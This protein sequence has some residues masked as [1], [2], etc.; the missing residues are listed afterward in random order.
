M[1]KYL[2]KSKD[3]LFSKIFLDPNN[4]RTAPEDRQGY[5]DPNTIFPESVQEPLLAR[6][7]G[8][9]EV[10]SLEPTITS[11]GWMP[12]DPMLVWEHPKKAGHYVV[13]EGNTRTVVLRRIRKKLVQE[14]AHLEKMEKN[15]A[16]YDKKDL[17]DQRK[18]VAKL[19]QIVTDTDTLNV[20]LIKAKS[21]AELEEWLPMLHGVRHI[22]H[23]QP[24][25]PYGTNLYLLSRYRQLF[26][27]ENGEKKDLTLD[28][29]IIQKL[30]DSVSLKPTKA[31][32][33]I[34]AAAAFSH[35]KKNYEH[36]MLKD[37][38]FTDQ[39]QYFFEEILQHEYPRKRFGF[40]KTDLHLSAEMEDVLFK[41]AFALPRPKNPKEGENPN[42]FRIAEDIRLWHQM[43][44]YD[45]RTGTTFAD[46]F[47][48]EDPD[49]APGMGEVEAEYLQKRAQV[50]PLV[51]LK[52]LLESL[53]DLKADT[54]MSQASHL[55]PMLKE[56]IKQ[57]ETYLT[58][59]EAVGT[60]K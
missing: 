36:K 14:A 59:I 37:E 41:W 20:H 57:A 43:S 13:I 12:I 38:S 3:V 48:V 10:D 21:A 22:S 58:M 19:Q 33:R 32:Q 9:N 54:L 16:K 31:R 25:S 26:E 2:D 11:R 45:N 50:S 39:D 60:K 56:V 4:P 17:E 1:H 35:F 24:W 27:A 18:L 15:K 55:R 5:E 51:T 44:R 49:S 7:E 34:Q 8:F 30:A 52:S 40:E 28:E 23:A 6:L 46:R 29:A 47:D 53:K 42:K